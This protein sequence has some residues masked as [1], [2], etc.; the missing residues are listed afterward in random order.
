MQA[1]W[2]TCVCTHTQ[3]ELPGPVCSFMMQSL[4]I[5]CYYRLSWGVKPCHCCAP[6]VCPQ[7]NSAKTWIC[8]PTN[9][10]RPPQSGQEGFLGQG[11]G[12]STFAQHDKAGKSFISQLLSRELCEPSSW[13]AVARL[14][15]WER[16][17]A[18]EPTQPCGFHLL[19]GNLH[20]MPSP[21]G[22]I[23]ASDNARTHT[24]THTRWYPAGVCSKW[25]AKTN[26]KAIAVEYAC[27]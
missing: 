22:L 6:I 8:S 1:L 17:R 21:S 19:W 15:S 9:A 26:F 3:S 5:G 14:R 10:V 23:T 20:Y 25:V 27:N 24:H 13:K 16:P 12:V 4:L 18:C 7:I 2:L 11:Q